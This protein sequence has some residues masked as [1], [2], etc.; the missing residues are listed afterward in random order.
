[1]AMSKERPGLLGQ[2]ARV[3]LAASCL[4]RRSEGL[5]DAA[6]VREDASSLAAGD[7]AL[8]AGEFGQGT[9]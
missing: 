9:Q 3:A 1:V 2:R 4:G 7:A 6:I 8:V 5:A